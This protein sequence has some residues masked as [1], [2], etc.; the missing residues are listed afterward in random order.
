MKSHQPLP[1]VAGAFARHS[2]VVMMKPLRT[3][4]MSTPMEPPWK[5]GEYQE[6]QCSDRTAPIASARMPSR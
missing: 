3:K 6:S 2:M 1:S 4:K 5:S